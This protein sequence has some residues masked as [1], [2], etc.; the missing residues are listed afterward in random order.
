MILE[1]QHCVFRS[2]MWAQ[3]SSLSCKMWG[4][5]FQLVLSI[6]MINSQPRRLRPHF[7]DPFAICEVATRI[8][9]LQEFAMVMC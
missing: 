7:Y 2:K 6:R 1:N 8:D 5:S 3:A 9:E 4:Q